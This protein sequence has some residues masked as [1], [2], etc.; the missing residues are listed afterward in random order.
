MNLK[1]IFKPLYL[2]DIKQQNNHPK[3][4]R[5]SGNKRGRR[6]HLNNVGMGNLAI[7][8]P[9]PGGLR[10]RQQDYATRRFLSRI[11]WPSPSMVRGIFY[12][13][14]ARALAN[15][16]FCA[17]LVNEDKKIHAE[18]MNEQRCFL[19]CPLQK[20]EFNTDRMGFGNF[21]RFCV[22]QKSMIL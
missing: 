10:G 6:K 5:R 14:R 8:E 1:T 22:Q 12:I 9:L 21:S 16:S 20:G 13:Q 2:D 3:T 4:L 7:R 19:G 15:G 17:N 11:F 18:L